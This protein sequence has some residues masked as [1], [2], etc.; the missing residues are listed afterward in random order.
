MIEEEEED[1]VEEEEDGDD[2][3]DDGDKKKGQE[4]KWDG[5]QMVAKKQK[6]LK[7]NLNCHLWGRRATE[8]RSH[9]AVF[10]NIALMKRSFADFFPVQFNRTCG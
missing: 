5:K 6:F 9:S 2:N 1:V 7:T 3:D 8:S 10:F 4:E